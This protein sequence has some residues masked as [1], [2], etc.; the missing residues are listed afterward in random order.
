MSYTE[1]FNKVSRTWGS[2]KEI[3]DIANCCKEI[4]THIRDNII[5]TI[6]LE[7]KDV[8]CTKRKV[9]STKRVLEYLDLDIEYIKN[10]ALKEQ[11]IT[12]A[13]TNKDKSNASIP[14]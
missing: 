8:P 12:K 2:V 6:R 9:V 1:L 14:R 7:N 5:K 3:M 10:M 11:E 4:A 13:I